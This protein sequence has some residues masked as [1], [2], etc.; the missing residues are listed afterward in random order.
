[1]GGLSSLPKPGNIVGEGIRK[2]SD[3]NIKKDFKTPEIGG[4]LK[5]GK[6][7]KILSSNV[8]SLP[9]FDSGIKNKGKGIFIM[10]RRVY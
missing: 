9:K 2:A 10:G 7:P 1:M 6:M 4:H 5:S 3:K 8:S